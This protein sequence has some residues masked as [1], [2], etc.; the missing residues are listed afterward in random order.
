MMPGVRYLPM[1]RSKAGEAAALAHL[2]SPMRDHVVPVFHLT[3]FPPAT[4]AAAV[5]S[6]WNGRSMALDGKFQCDMTGSTR[7]FES[8]FDQIGRGRVALIPSIECHAF[9]DYLTAVRVLRG[10]YAPGV[11]VKARPSQL[12][13]VAA[14]CGAQDWPPDQIDLV[15]NLGDI[16]GFDPTALATVVRQGLLDHVPNPSSWRSLALAASAAPRDESGLLPGRNIVR[17]TEWTLWRVAAAAIPQSLDYAD[18]STAHPDLSDPPG[19]A[20][21]KALVSVRYTAC[22]EW[23]ILRGSSVADDA[24][25]RMSTQYRAHAMALVADARFGGLRNCWADDQIR[26]IAEGAPGGGSRSAWAAIITS[27]HLSVVANEINS[28]AQSGPRSRHR[29]AHV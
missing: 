6:A 27:R 19:Y 16:A 11:L 3:Q 14:W 1:L 20:I 7:D 17:R 28:S 10:R 2:A 21:T 15:V 29:S 8:M 9:S 18:F 26:K 5:S 23:I 13:E 22:D 24:S 12:H 4:F 25:N